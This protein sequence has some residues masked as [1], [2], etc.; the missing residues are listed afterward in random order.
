MLV[1]SMIFW[2]FSYIW[3]KNVFQYLSPTLTVFTRLILVTIMF[4]I[5]ALL[6]KNLNKLQKG[7]WKRFLVLAFFEPFLYYIGESYGLKLVSPTVASVIIATIPL[8][9]AISMFFLAKEPIKSGT[10][11]GLIISFF[12]VLMVVLNKDLSFSA[13]PRGILFLMLAVSSVSG[14]SFMLQK[15]T[16]R[17]NAFSV[18]FYQNAVGIFLF[19]PLVLIFDVKNF[20]T[21]TI[22]YDLIKNLL[23][24]SFF[25]SGLA[26]FMFAY[27]TQ[28][29][30]VTKASIFTYL[31]PIF[32]GIIS[33]AYGYDTFTYLQM[34][35]VLV[36]VFGLSISQ[37]KIRK[38]FLK[39]KMAD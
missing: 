18:I 5:I 39:N 1:L 26:F 38:Y 22:T 33:F 28:K 6:F 23:I 21:I 15:L 11:I 36:V 19:L 17:Y 29:M 30:G 9:I 37:L 27:G 16:A 32:T 10:Y 7:D 31:I 34:S 24:L 14:Y 13:S 12:G 3:T 4:S 8:F 2:S 25:S 35:G 20:P